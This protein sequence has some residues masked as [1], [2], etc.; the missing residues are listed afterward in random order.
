LHATYFLFGFVRCCDDSLGA[1]G[2]YRGVDQTVVL[3]EANARLEALVCA[4]FV[5][6]VLSQ[7]FVNLDTF[8]LGRQV[9]RIGRR[10]ESNGSVGFSDSVNVHIM[11]GSSLDCGAKSITRCFGIIIRLQAS[12][13]NLVM[14]LT[15]SEHLVLGAFRTHHFC[16]LAHLFE[17]FSGAV[18]WSSDDSSSAGHTTRDTLGHADKVQGCQIGSLRLDL[19]HTFRSRSE[20]RINKQDHLLLGLGLEIFAQIGQDFNVWHLHVRVGRDLNKEHG[21]GQLTLGLC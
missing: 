11:L 4:E 14:V 15:E 13:L 9:E 12:L 20:G 7:G 2:R 16:D 1:R 3:T 19:L 10:S 8:A 18:G 21:H 5:H 6:K 17:P